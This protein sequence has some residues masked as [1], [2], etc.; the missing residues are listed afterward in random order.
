MKVREYLAQY[1]TQAVA[2]SNTYPTI[3]NL[4][5]EIAGDMPSTQTDAW[6][7]GKIS[8]F[9]A[10]NWKWMASTSIYT[11][12]LSSGQAVYSLTT[13]MHF[14]DIKQVSVSDSTVLSTTALWTDYSPAGADDEIASQSY[15]KALNGVGLYPVP[16]SDEHGQYLMVVHS[17]SPPRYTSTGDSSTILAFPAK[18][19]QGAKSYVKAEIA[20][21]GDAPDVN[22]RNNHWADMENIVRKARMDSYKRQAQNPKQRWDYR[23]K[24]WKGD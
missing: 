13:N 18:W 7:I 3:Q 24:W 12:T 15:F 17:P 10:Q 14:E 19:L 22:L 6:R 11:T 1:S 23:A 16:T 21:S 5:D 2:S 8:D 20:G 9:L 4:L